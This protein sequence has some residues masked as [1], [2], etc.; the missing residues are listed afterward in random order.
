MIDQ[1]T[2][3]DSSYWMY[4]D[5]GNYKFIFSWDTIFPDIPE[6]TDPQDRTE[7][8]YSLDRHGI[9]ARTLHDRLYHAG[10]KNYSYDE[11]IDHNIVEYCL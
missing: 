3:T 6:P 10:V 11:T 9:D 4:R 1:D 2:E 7:N 5:G 8:G